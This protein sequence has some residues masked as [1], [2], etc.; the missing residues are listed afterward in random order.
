MKHLHL[1]VLITIL[2]ISCTP[3]VEQRTPSAKKSL[4]NSITSPDTTITFWP[5]EFDKLTKDTNIQI[6]NEHYKLTIARYSLNDSSIA[7]INK[8]GNDIR[9]DVYHNY[10]FRI[11]LFS[12]SGDTIQNLTLDKTTFKDSLPTEFYQ[13]SVLWNVKYDAVRSNRLC[14]TVELLVPDTDWATWGRMA[15]FFRTDKKGKID[16]WD[17]KNVE[18]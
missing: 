10:E 3:S 16:F 1:C 8:Q 11:A 17:F 14:Y 18:M 9:K 7:W 13:R 2:L 4:Q 6:D 15:I 5:T 12:A